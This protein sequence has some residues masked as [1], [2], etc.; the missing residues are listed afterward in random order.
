MGGRPATE[1]FLESC[2]LAIWKLEHASRTA[3]LLCSRTIRTYGDLRAA[4][5]QVSPGPKESGVRRSKS[6]QRAKGAKGAKGAPGK[7]GVTE[8]I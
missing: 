4:Q 1:H 2:R 5:L 7:P 6:E 8:T 3:E